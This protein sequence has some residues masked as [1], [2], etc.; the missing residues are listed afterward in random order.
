MQGTP[1]SPRTPNPTQPPIR[2][3]N[4]PPLA[5]ANGKARPM[6]ESRKRFGPFQFSGGRYVTGP[7]RFS[8]TVGD[9]PTHTVAVAEL[10][11]PTQTVAFI[12]EDDMRAC[13]HLLAAAPDLLNALR[14][15]TLQALQ[16]SVLERDACVAMARA[17][18]AK[19]EGRD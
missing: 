15:I 7:D 5:G 19:A 6:T 8:E 14:A 4:A 9:K 13:G 2:N 18:I 11:F 17:A 1:A 12:D 16:G 10:R 3:S